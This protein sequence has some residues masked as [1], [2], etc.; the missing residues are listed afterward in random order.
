MATDNLKTREA[1]AYLNVSR[2]TLYRL[3]A[4]GYVRAARLGGLVRWPLRELE[5]CLRRWRMR[6]RA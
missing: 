4:R 5:S 3:E 2:P 6:R 1:C